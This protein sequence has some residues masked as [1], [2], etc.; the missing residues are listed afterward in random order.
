MDSKEQA[1]MIQHPSGGGPQGVVKKK[2]FVKIGRPG[3]CLSLVF[4]LIATL[5]SCSELDRQS[6]YFLR[7]LIVMTIRWSS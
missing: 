3:R 7:W 4:T 2:V 1:L 5:W 6:D